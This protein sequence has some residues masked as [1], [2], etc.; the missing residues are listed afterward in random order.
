MQVTVSDV[1]RETRNYF[2]RATYS[3]C[4]TVAQGQLLLSKPLAARSWVALEGA[5][6]PSGVYQL[7]E[8]GRLPDCP[9]GSWTGRV[10]LLSPSSDFLRLCQEIQDWAAA[11][12]DST[13]RAE[14]FG[15]YSCT[16]SDSSWQAVF[17]HRLRAYQKMFAEVNC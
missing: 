3:G 10:H 17:Q 1:M 16:R 7:D 15:E 11:H 5:D 14:R 12:P 2:L 13:I 4:F 9:D 6:A 8:D